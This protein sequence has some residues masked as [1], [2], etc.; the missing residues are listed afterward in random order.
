MAIGER[1]KSLRKFLKLTQQQ[2]ADA[3]D[4]DQGHIAGIEK[5][6]KNPSKSLQKVICLTFYVN[7]IWLKT[8]GGEMFISPEESLKKIKVHFDKQTFNQAI[9]NIMKDEEDAVAPDPSTGANHSCQGNPRDIIN[10]AINQYGATA[11]IEAFQQVMKINGLAVAA[12]YQTHRADTGDPELDRLINIL[13]DL[14]A[15]GDNRLKG[16][17]SIQFDRAF[18]NDVVEKAQKKH[19]ENQGQ[20]SVG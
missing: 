10:I 17:A 6:S 9:I 16:W 7:D 8:G 14:W 4:I 11:I 19:A 15:A 5:G 13:Y 1:I 18:P 3:L 12:S 2:F 20:A